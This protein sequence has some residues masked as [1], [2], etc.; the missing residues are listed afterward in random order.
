LFHSGLE[1]N[2]AKIVENAIIQ[3]VHRFDHL[4]V[5]LRAVHDVGIAG[6]GR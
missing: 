1:Y 2:Y 3:L 5:L 6:T 4:R